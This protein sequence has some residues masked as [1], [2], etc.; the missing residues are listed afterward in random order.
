MLEVSP[1]SC[2]PLSVNSR[3]VYGRLT[4]VNKQVTEYIG[5]L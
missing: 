3:R 2:S 4:F 1:G 5:T